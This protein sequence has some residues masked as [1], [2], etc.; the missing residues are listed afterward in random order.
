MRYTPRSLN[1]SIALGRGVVRAPRRKSRTGYQRAPNSKCR[2]TIPSRSRYGKPAADSTPP[3]DALIAR[4]E[5]FLESAILEKA[6]ES[7]ND[8]NSAVAGDGEAVRGAHRQCFH[9]G[10][11]R[12]LPGTLT[13][14]PALANSTSRSPPFL[15]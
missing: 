10:F 12:S 6:S 1:R 13:L 15:S 2:R 7:P 11:F 14:V 5:S 9:F 8:P 4:E 3:R